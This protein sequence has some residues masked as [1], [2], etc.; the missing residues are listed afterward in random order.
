[1]SLLLKF[2]EVVEVFSDEDE[3]KRRM[4]EGKEAAI[5]AQELPVHPPPFSSSHVPRPMV[6]TAKWSFD[7]SA[8]DA[9]EAQHCPSLL[10]P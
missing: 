1:M 2:L 7:L 8:T 10:G 4:K 3:F 5:Y 9:N 6:E